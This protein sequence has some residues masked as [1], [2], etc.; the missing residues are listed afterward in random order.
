LHL[1]LHAGGAV[2]SPAGFNAIGVTVRTVTDR[3]RVARTRPDKGASA[4]EYGLIVALIAVVIA[5]AVFA[6]GSTLR[7]R[8]NQGGECVERIGKTAQQ[9]TPGG[10]GGPG[11]GGPGG[12]GP[13]GR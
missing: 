9:C 6:L 5:A 4:V 2:R 1:A 13:G 3:I 12:G 10:G 8:F 7:Q 11:G